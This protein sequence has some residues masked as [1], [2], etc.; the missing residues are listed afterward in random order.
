[1]LMPGCVPNG[2]RQ[3]SNEEKKLFLRGKIEFRK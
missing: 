2:G 3:L 1:M